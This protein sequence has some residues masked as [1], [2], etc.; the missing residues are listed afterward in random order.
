MDLQKGV[1]GVIVAILL[2]VRVGCYLNSIFNIVVV[3]L[4]D[5]LKDLLKDTVD[6]IPA[7]I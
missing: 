6:I 1:L 5:N 3:T 2:K 7:I 4:L